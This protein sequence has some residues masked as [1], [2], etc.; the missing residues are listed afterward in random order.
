MPQ[1]DIVS[2]MSQLFWLLI[3]LGIFY[4]LV[5]KYILPE[6]KKIQK[7][8]EISIL[9]EKPLSLALY[10]TT[11]YETL[12]HQEEILKKAELLNQEMVVTFLKRTNK[13]RLNNW[14]YLTKITQLLL[15]TQN[16]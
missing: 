3:V 6:L 14:N 12:H 2:Y 9:Q 7:V 10:Q 13:E 15:K 5:L 8:R 16:S 11:M 1:L 4:L